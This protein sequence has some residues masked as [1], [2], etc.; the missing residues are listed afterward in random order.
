[1]ELLL[2]IM[3]EHCEFCPGTLA[4][5][6]PRYAML[7]SFKLLQ[8]ATSNTKLVELHIHMTVNNLFGP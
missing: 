7:H 4:D 3:Q 5:L 8:V 2:K 6:L 1:M